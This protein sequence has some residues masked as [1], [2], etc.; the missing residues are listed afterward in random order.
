M[1][2]DDCG[3]TDYYTGSRCTVFVGDRLDGL[4]KCDATFY[5]DGFDCHLEQT[6]PPGTTHAGTQVCNVSEENLDNEVLIYD[7]ASSGCVGTCAPGYHDGGDGAC[8]RTV[9]S[10]LSERACSDNFQNNGLGEC[11]PICAPNFHR[12]EPD[13]LCTTMLDGQGKCNDAQGYYDGGGGQCRVKPDPDPDSDPD[14]TPRTCNQGYHDLGTRVCGSTS[15]SYAGHGSGTLNCDHGY[16]DGGTTCVSATDGIC[17]DGYRDD[18]TGT[19]CADNTVCADGFALVRTGYASQPDA[20]ACIPTTAATAYNQPNTCPPNMT[21][22]TTTTA[23]TATTAGTAAADKSLCLLKQLGP[24]TPNDCT[25]LGVKLAAPAALD[26]VFTATVYKGTKD[27]TG[28]GSCALVNTATETAT[29]TATTTAPAAEAVD[30]SET[31][32]DG[33]LAFG[34]TIGVLVVIMVI[35]GA[36]RYKKWSEEKQNAQSASARGVMV[37]ISK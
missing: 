23:A 37:K 34:L 4:Q 15:T 25:E 14:T 16:M 21:E 10:N 36:V 32:N 24:D 18:G 27:G 5:F 26:L 30:G 3:G 33:W 29:E 2:I 7:A 9:T 17:E 31:S 19:R 22:V 20:T 1:G 12:K 8:L 35:G 11:V 13:E 6:Y 28:T